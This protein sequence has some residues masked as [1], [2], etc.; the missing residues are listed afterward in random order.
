MSEVLL[1][2]NAA[3][4]RASNLSSVLTF[5]DR[6]DPQCQNGGQCIGPGR[7]RCP[8]GYV[9]PQ[10]QEGRLSMLLEHIY[11]IIMQGGGLILNNSLSPKGY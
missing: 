8:T 4:K 5:L 3:A 2:G 1:A 9:G 10:C 6:C 7:C 11:D